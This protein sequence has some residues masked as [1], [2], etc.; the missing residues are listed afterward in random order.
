MMVTLRLY[1]QHDLDLI[2]LY[3]HPSFSLPAAIKR[4]LF[5]Y[6]NMEQ[7]TIKQPDPY[8]LPKEKISKTVQIHIFLD[9]E[10]D[11]NII[12]W[13]KS[14]KEGYRNSVLKNIVR[15]YLAAPCIYSYQDNESSND[16][17]IQNNDLFE[18]NIRNITEIKGRA[19]Q[20]RKKKKEDKTKRVED[21]KLASEI[22][23]RKT[24][25]KENSDTIFV[26]RIDDNDIPTP[27]ITGVKNE[28]IRL[29][30]KESVNKNNNYNNENVNN[31]ISQEEEDDMFGMFDDL[32][33]SMGG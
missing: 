29:A 32:M 25:R 28:Q 1:R 15:G 17:A 20:T 9:E 2:T 23:N 13:L 24:V 8:V 10:K 30:Q 11:K 3:R 26:E 19:V 6:V 4:S 14:T 33:K 7:L 12:T 22:L 16:I 31:E 18:S 27:N 5:A 21:S